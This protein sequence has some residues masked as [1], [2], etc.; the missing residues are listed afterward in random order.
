MRLCVLL[1]AQRKINQGNN[2][3][4]NRKFLFSRVRASPYVCVCKTVC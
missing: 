2:T 4:T 3:L 1:R